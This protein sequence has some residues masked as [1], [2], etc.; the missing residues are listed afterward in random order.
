MAAPRTLVA[1]VPSVLLLWCFHQNLFKKETLVLVLQSNW[2][3]AVVV[4]PLCSPVFHDVWFVHSWNR[5]P[6][7]HLLATRFATNTLLIVCRGPNFS[8][9]S[10]PSLEARHTWQIGS[11]GGVKLPTVCLGTLYQCSLRFDRCL[12][13]KVS[14]PLGPQLMFCLCHFYFPVNKFTLRTK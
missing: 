4:A 14:L 3:V 5:Q 12:S 11:E 8:L 10:R 6:L 1:T 9:H 7:S 2:R 13:P